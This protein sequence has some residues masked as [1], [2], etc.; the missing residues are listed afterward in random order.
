[1]ML[2]RL[3]AEADNLNRVMPGKTSNRKP[4]SQ[5]F[6]KLLTR[7]IVLALLV[8]LGVTSWLIITLSRHVMEVEAAERY[9][10]VMLSTSENVKSTLSDVR[11]AA[12]NNVYEIEQSLNDPDEMFHIM[13]RIVSLN[14]Q[15]RSCG[16]SFKENYYPQKGRSF[17]PLAVRN[18]D[19]TARSYD[20][21][22]EMD[23]LNEPWFQE[24][25]KSDKP[26]WSKPFFEKNDSLTP[27]ISYLAPIR[28]KKGETV[29]VLGADLSLVWL[30][31]RLEKLD[32]ST[33]KKLWDKE[34]EIEDETDYTVKEDEQQVENDS[35]Q[36]VVYSFIITKDGTYI[37]HPD[38]KRILRK[39]FFDYAT[40]STDTLDDHAGRQMSKGLNGFMFSDSDNENK[41]QIEGQERYLIY[42]PLSEIN[43]SMGIVVP[44]YLISL[45]GYIFIMVLVIIFIISLIVIFTVCRHFIK[46]ATRPLMQLAASAGEVAKGNFDTSLPVTKNN[47]EIS[48]LRDSFERMQDSLANYVDELKATTTQKASMERDLNIAHG[49]QMAMLPGASVERDDVTVHGILTPAK[50]VGGD[51]FDFLVRNDHLFFCIGDVSG[52]GIPASLVMAVMRS[53]FHNISEHVN[54]PDII[55]TALNEAM[56]ERNENNI[57]VTFFVGVLDLSNGQL[58][59]CNAGHDAPLLIGHE[60]KQLPCDA[61][62]P[63]GVMP[64]FPF[65]SQQTVLE[66]QT[67]IFLFTDGPDEAEAEHNTQCGDERVGRIAVSVAAEGH[68]Q[69]KPLIDAMLQAVHEFVGNAEQSDDLTMLAVQYTKRIRNEHI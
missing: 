28:N 22:S 42:A 6:A 4:Y 58:T 3:R 61:N 44:S 13:E 20:M 63:I 69:P 39:T 66:P 29:A 36:R 56:N 8:T 49:I 7:R 51:L 30:C 60:V 16:I 37:S 68:H 55:M 34:E 40:M 47:D 50:A 45:N 21:G 35:L 31:K 24:A 18:A 12:I 54:Q 19:G 62:L 59:Y 64:E 2:G 15:I 1:M 65:T 23:Y 27:L 57:F 10:E 52:K 48:L 33:F 32:L 11:V 41:L 26:Y 67:T 53:L 9:Q 17:Q 14:E 38:K 43:W 25:M 5:S 46:R